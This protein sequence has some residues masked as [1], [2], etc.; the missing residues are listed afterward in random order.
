[1][2]ATRGLLIALF[3]SGCS[4]YQFGNVNDASLYG[5]QCVSQAMNDQFLVKWRTAVPPEYQKNI[6]S[7]GSLI[8]RFPGTTKARVEKEILQQHLSDYAV[9]EYEFRIT[10]TSTSVSGGTNNAPVHT[11]VTGPTATEGTWGPA[12]INAQAAWSFLGNEG[13]GV[14]VAVVDSGADINNPLLSGNIWVNPGEIPNNGIDDEGD[15]YVDD[16]NGW[17]FN[18]NQSEV[19]DEAN[20][21][22]HVSGIIA[23]QAGADSFTGVAPHA[24]IMPLKFIDATGSG[25]IGDAI[26]AMGYAAAHGAKIINASWGGSECSSILGQEIATTAAQGILFVNAAGNGNAENVGQD[27]SVAPEWPASFQIPGKITVGSYNASEVL[28]TF[29]N[30]GALVDLAAPG[31][32]IL[33]TVPPATGQFEGPNLAIKSGTSMATPFVAG[34]AAL[35]YSAKPTAT[36]VEIAAAITGGVQPAGFKVRSAGKLNALGAAQ[37]LMS[38]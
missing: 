15:G 34:V 5:A 32:N 11:E 10:S 8:T 1:M 22:T 19:L 17:D 24:K 18:A 2:D 37:Y 3:L 14:I 30:F 6:L 29:S 16:V 21:G 31:E 20:H 28:S 26:T 27:I 13:D 4:G 12:D 25:P 35:L 38:H 7:P 9:A 33:S 23:G 36:A